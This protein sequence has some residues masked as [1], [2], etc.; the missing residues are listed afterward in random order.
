MSQLQGHHQIWVEEARSEEA[1]EEGCDVGNE[2]EEGQ[3]GVSSSQAGTRLPQVRKDDDET[4]RKIW[5]LLGLSQLST[6]SRD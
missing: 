6:M 1:T 3:S 2:A 4:E 5:S